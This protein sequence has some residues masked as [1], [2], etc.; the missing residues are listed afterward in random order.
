V[1]IVVGRVTVSE[2]E[3]EAAVGTRDWYHL[4]LLAAFHGTLVGVDLR[5][6]VNNCDLFN[7]QKKTKTNVIKINASYFIRNCLA[8][9]GR[10]VEGSS[11]GY[12]RRPSPF[13]DNFLIILFK[14][15][16]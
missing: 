12:S 4:L 11:L 14:N 1:A 3:V 6:Q 10:P 16:K 2:A 9:L 8:R 15:Y 7:Y 13:K 5:L